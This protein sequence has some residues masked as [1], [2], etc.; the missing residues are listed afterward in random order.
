MA[1]RAGL[2]AAS[3]LRLWPIAWPLFLELLLG[4]GVGA[5]GTV[6]A[7][8]LG[9]AAGAA[10][11]LANQV[12]TAFFILFRVVGAGI[13]VVV[14]QSLGAGRPDSAAATAKAALGASTWVGAALAAAALLLAHPLVSL[15]Q[16][17]PEVAPL[18]TALL[19]ALAPALLLD[20]WNASMAV[21]MRAHLRARD[22]L[23][24]MVAMHSLH[25]LLV[26][27]LMF[28][29]GAWAG[30]GLLGFAAAVVAA[31]L[32]AL[33]LHQ[34]FWRH[35]LGLRTH[36]DDWL[37]WRSAELRPVA[38]IGLPGAAENMGWRLA[39]L[40]SVAAVASLGTGALA[41]HA[42]TYQVMMLILLFG[43]ATGLAAEVLV[44]HQIG[45]GH[46][47]AAD[48]LVRRSMA[49]GLAVSFTVAL[50]AALT[51]PWLMRLFTSDPQIIQSASRLL[52][53]T[54]LL[55]PGRTFN[56]VVINALRAAGDARYPVLAGSASMLIVLAGGSWFM[57]HVWGW[58]LE[59]VWLAYA[60]DE[61]LRGLLMWR[62][63]RQLKWVP[64]ARASRRAR[65]RPG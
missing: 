12:F 44:G 61:W 20:A 50:G 32:L 37:R 3:S 9:D 4:M 35:R 16:A 1:A 64:Y 49:R 23:V 10:F 22:T 36:W 5:V 28:G 21:V 34:W 2:P 60:A 7:A 45:A 26:G 15:M 58:G 11:A 65:S 42:Y 19:M 56:L 24:V 62:R 40:V 53:I 18:A 41:T 27:P 63:W 48:Q 30:W 8:R 14:T 31:R 51:G 54:V 17:P 39:F 52:W 46:F 6:L 57:V 25:V 43:L 33:L 13:G 59:G 38:H 47:R 55:E 29:W